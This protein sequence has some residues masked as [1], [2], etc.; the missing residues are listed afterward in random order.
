MRDAGCRLLKI[1]RYSSVFHIICNGTECKLNR[2]TST[3]AMLLT[4]GLSIL[5][6]LIE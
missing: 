5:R 2:Y 1:H 3:S 4:R 6:N